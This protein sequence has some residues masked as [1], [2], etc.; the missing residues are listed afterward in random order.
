MDKQSTHCTFILRECICI[1]RARA[2]SFGDGN[3]ILRS[4]RPDRSNAGSRISTR[5]V[6]AITYHGINTN[7]SQTH[8][9][10]KKA[11]LCFLAVILSLP[12]EGPVLKLLLLAFFWFHRPVG[13]TLCTNYRQIWQGG[14]G[15]QHL[16]HC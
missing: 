11:A 13:T 8:Y 16:T 1:M 15:R 4:S 2:S 5:L 10:H 6:A 12:A 7:V 9:T 3:S 14:G